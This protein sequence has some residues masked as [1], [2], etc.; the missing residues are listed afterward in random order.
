MQEHEL[1]PVPAGKLTHVVGI[2]DAGSTTLAVRLAVDAHR[3][4]EKVLYV[5]WKS[6]FDAAY[7]RTL[8]APVGGD[9][10]ASG[11]QV[12]WPETVEAGFRL[13][14]W[15]VDQGVRFVVLDQPA[16]APM[17]TA[18]LSRPDTFESFGREAHA[19]RE[20]YLDEIEA[21]SS[22][23]ATVLVLSGVRPAV[24]GVSITTRTPWSP[25]VGRSRVWLE[26]ITGARASKFTRW[27]GD[28]V[29]D[30]GVVSLGRFGLYAPQG[31]Q[32]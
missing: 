25:P 28:A 1:L 24:G 22:C 18:I 32:S 20:F 10:F 21:L 27:E 23:G 31:A 16:A 3:R 2:R 9:G 5:D 4:G 30:E 8:G 15:V 7:W 13:A 26:R 19:K 12:A 11:F 17:T 29:V 14:R 6:E